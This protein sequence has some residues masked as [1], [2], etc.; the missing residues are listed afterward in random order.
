M[1]KTGVISV[2]IV[3]DHAMMRAGL[4]ALLDPQPDMEVVAEA[5][6]GQE[7][8][9]AYAQHRPDVVLMD[10]KMPVM[11]G[12]AATVALRRDFPG[13]NILLITTYQGDPDI[14]RCLRAGARR[15]ILKD[16][17]RAELVEAVRSAM[18]AT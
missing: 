15:Y 7:A 14:E 5:A 6:N 4:R 11:D 16:R 3:D 18:H 1:T 17:L 9:L 2:L 10:L 8:T 13:A 12:L